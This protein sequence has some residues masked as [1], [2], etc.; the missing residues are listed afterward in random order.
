[1]QGGNRHVAAARG[2]VAAVGRVERP[3]G[4]QRVAVG[5]CRARSISGRT[6]AAGPVA[7]II[8]A[9]RWGQT[10]GSS[11]MPSADQV[12]RWGSGCRGSGSE[13]VG[14]RLRIDLRH[15]KAESDTRAALQVANL[16]RLDVAARR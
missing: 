3:L 15:A 14:D 13:H 2:E 7:T 8:G 16:Q 9:G 12:L 10:P 4:T 6:C 11:R 5:Q 1:M